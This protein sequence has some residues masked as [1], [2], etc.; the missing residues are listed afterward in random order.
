VPKGSLAHASTDPRTEL[1]PTSETPSV[2]PGGKKCLA[3]ESLAPPTRCEPSAW[4]SHRLGPRTGQSFL[5]K[6]RRPARQRLGLALLG[7]VMPGLVDCSS[8]RFPRSSAGVVELCL[9][10]FQSRI[11]LFN[12]FFASWGPIVRGVMGPAVCAKV[13]RALRNP[14]D[15]SQKVTKTQVF[16]KRASAR[17]HGGPRFPSVGASP[18]LEKASKKQNLASAETGALP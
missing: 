2:L 12:P 9:V 6:R 8:R 16:P 18:A 3:G 1:N 14:D 11:F 17:S 7:L 15:G 10:A 4:P 13:L 5:R